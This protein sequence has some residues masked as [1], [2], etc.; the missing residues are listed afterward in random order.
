MQNGHLL[1]VGLAIVL[2][3]EDVVHGRQTDILVAA[4][5][6]GDEVAVEQF[7]VIFGV[8]AGLR[9]ECHG[10]AGVAVGIGYQ[11]AERIENGNGVVGDIVQEGVADTQR[12]CRESV[13][14]I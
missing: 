2:G 11:V 12:A 1:H 7:V 10:I 3:V 9:I 4:A 13:H 14:R 8:A 5:V 6:A